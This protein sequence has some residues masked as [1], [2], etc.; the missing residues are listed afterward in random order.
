MPANLSDSPAGGEH[1]EPRNASFAASTSPE[2]TPPAYPS[3]PP[4][5]GTNG[6]WLAIYALAA[7]ISA[8]GAILIARAAHATTM[9][10]ATAGGATFLAV[11]GV[12]ITAHRFLKDR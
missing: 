12:T 9:E 5:P 7:V 10:T 6:I 1:P 4:S 3:G 2:R 11:L 8:L